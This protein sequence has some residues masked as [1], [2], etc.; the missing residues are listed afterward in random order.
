VLDGTPHTVLGVMPEG[1]KF[2]EY[3]T[4]EFWVPLP[5]TGE[6]AGN[7]VELV[8]RVDEQG[9]SAAELASGP[10]AAGLFGERQGLDSATVRLTSMEAR[11]GGYDELRQAAWLLFSAVGLILLVAASNAFNLLLVRTADRGRELAVRRA[12]GASRGRVVRQLMTETLGLALIAGAVAVAVA[13]FATRALQDLLPDTLVFFLPHAIEVEQR[14]LTVAFVLAIAAG[15]VLGVLPALVS[16][17][18]GRSVRRDGLTPY[19]AYTP[20]RTRLRRGLVVAEV[21]MAII[22]LTGAGLLLNSFLRLARVDIGVDTENLALLTLSVT[23]TT[24]GDS[25]RESTFLPTLEERIRGIPGVLGATATGHLPSS[26]LYFG[27][28]L[29]AEGRDPAGRDPEMWPSADVSSDFFEVLG[30]RLIAGRSFRSGETK[31][32]DVAIIDRDLARYLW[33]TE[34]PLGRR[35]RM[36]ENEPWLTV[37]G[38]V[39]DLLLEAR[40]GSASDFV[41]LYPFD[42]TQ[43]AGYST[44][45]IRTA[46]HPTA[47]FPA[48]RAA[49]RELAPNLPIDEL[50]LAEEVYAED[51]QMPRFLA[52]LVGVLG[53]FGLILAAVGVFSVLAY[54]VA[55][56]SREIGV[57]MALGATAGE[58]QRMVVRQGLFL[59]CLGA[60]LGLAAVLVLSR[61]LGGMLFELEPTDPATLAAVVA[62]MLVVAAAAS[63]VPAQRT[64]RVHP[65]EAIRA[66]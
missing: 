31:A 28:A 54:E 24:V 57:R 62:I 49:V 37:V 44:V 59:T 15:T 55:Q 12:L 61:Y 14:A 41:L 64:T 29:Q 45:A 48:V 66:E 39:D 6:I 18:P 35:F 9:I 43:P 25:A 2:P 8:A 1:F 23:R 46:G 38:V 47:V 30:A 5:L 13:L 7:R 36:R 53:G 11:R 10:L 58:M 26:M 60:A 4:T 51:I 42:A 56:R 19:A 17:R 20:A 27:T 52:F 21:T 63:L 50:T 32:D 16:T 22:L 40:D 65:A 33:E 34:D 3:S